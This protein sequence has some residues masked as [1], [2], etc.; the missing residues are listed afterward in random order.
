MPERAARGSR[1]S[2]SAAFI[3]FAE[4]ECRGVSPLYETLAAAVARDP[5]LLA[6]AGA[7]R[8]GQ[9]VPNLFFAAVH[10]LLSDEPAKRDP[11]AH[12]Y[13]GLVE[14]T[15]PSTDAFPAFR[16]F[17]LAHA[18]ALA[19][20]INRRSVNTNE[21]GRCAVL[22]LGYAEISRMLRAVSF[23][24]VEIGASAGLNLF[25]DNYRYEYERGPAHAPVMADDLASPV[26]IGCTIRGMV[27]PPLH[28]DDPL[29]NASS[30]ASA[31]SSSR[32]V[33]TLRTMLPGCVHWSGPNS[34]SGPFVSI[35]RSLLPERR[36]VA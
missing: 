19:E 24:L 30:G 29:P 8:A 17:C 16:R 21:V 32:L 14:L 31:S 6:L 3:S 2:L 11:L 36:G 18:G 15:A 26:Q 23:A 12:Y 5:E 34:A 27:Q 4:H 28:P 20:I 9:P 13:P 10:L 22:R 1:A 25:W 33:S 35:M 7:A